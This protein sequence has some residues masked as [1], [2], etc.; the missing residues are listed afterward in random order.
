MSLQ[1]LMAGVFLLVGVVFFVLSIPELKWLW[2]N[3][4]IKKKSNSETFTSDNADFFGSVEAVIRKIGSP[5]QLKRSAEDFL[6]M[7]VVT[8]FPHKAAQIVSQQTY[9]SVNVPYSDLDN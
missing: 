9:L 1:W 7:N 3:R 5:E 4:S 8:A 6:R 2:K